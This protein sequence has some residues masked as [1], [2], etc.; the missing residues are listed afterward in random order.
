MDGYVK[1]GVNID[2]VATLRN[3]RGGFHPDPI[4]AAEVAI[5]A[6]ADLITVHLREDRRHIIDE[7]VRRLRAMTDLPV[8]LEVGATPVMVD[9]AIGFRPHSVC[10]VPE[11][12]QERTTEG[13]LDACGRI[14]FLRDATAALRQSGVAVTLFLEP[15][16]AQVVA[17]KEI[18]ANAIEF[19]TGR[20][21][22][23]ADA[24]QAVELQRIAEAAWHASGLGIACH[25]GHGLTFANVVP[26]AAIKE[27]EEL[28]IGHF[29]VGEAVFAG[30]TTVIARMRS[31]IANARR[32]EPASL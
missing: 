28:N 16:S 25:A 27:I 14:D 18:G 3:A 26:I 2:H 30:L 8:N 23:T 20:Y 1:L 4:R 11:R 24:E 15:D 12:R 19:H 7:D 6:G 9:L 32:P 17:A 31:L 5:R 10:F 21:C 22:D 13:G 29:I